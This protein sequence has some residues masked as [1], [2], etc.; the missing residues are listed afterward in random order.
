M[1]AEKLWVDRSEDLEG[2][3]EE[4]TELDNV[5]VFYRC[6]LIVDNKKD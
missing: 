2:D 3:A 1:R 5:D 6:I 4:R